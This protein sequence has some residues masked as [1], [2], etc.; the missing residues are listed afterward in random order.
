MSTK[1]SR[2]KLL[3]RPSKSSQMTYSVLTT[4]KNHRKSRLQNYHSNLISSL[5]ELVFSCIILS[6]CT[7]RCTKEWKTPKRIQLP[8]RSSTLDYNFWSNSCTSLETW[9]V[10]TMKPIREMPRFSRPTSSTMT[11]ASFPSTL[12]CYLITKSILSSS[13]L[14][15][16]SLLILCWKC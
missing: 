1:K 11:C 6:S 14:T 15:Q 16:S 13:L 12:S 7:S 8:T 10:Q 4:D 9:L 5:L 2:G 3:R